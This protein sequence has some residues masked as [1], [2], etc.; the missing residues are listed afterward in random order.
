MH[1]QTA[2]GISGYDRSAACR[3]MDLN[4]IGSMQLVAAAA[5]TDIAVARVRLSMLRAS[6]RERP[7][8]RS[9]QGT[10]RGLGGTRVDRLHDAEALELLS[11]DAYVGLTPRTDPS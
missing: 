7:R 4:F 6:P 3:R 1:W 9:W 10:S 5:E 2:P 11:R 8:P